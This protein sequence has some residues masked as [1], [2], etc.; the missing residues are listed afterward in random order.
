MSTGGAAG[1]SGIVVVRYHVLTLT[2]NS[3]KGGAAPGTVTN[4]N[5]T[6]MTQSVTNSPVAVGAQ[7]QYVC[8]G[9][10]L[11]GNADTNG[12]TS[13]SG[14]NVTLTL[15]NNATLTWGWTTNYWLELGTNGSGSVAPGSGFYA[16]GSSVTITATAGEQFRFTGWSGDTGGCTIDGTNLTTASLSGPRAITGNF[17]KVSSGTVIIFRIGG[18]PLDASTPYG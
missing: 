4:V 5:G 14:T 15:T 10:A 12:A 2:V 16:A 1:G 13:G 8:S 9:W 7:T 6:L 3:D 17:Q 18:Y 11:A